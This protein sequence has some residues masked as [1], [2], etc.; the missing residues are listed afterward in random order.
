[1]IAPLD[2]RDLIIQAQEQTIRDLRQDVENQSALAK[3]RAE[4]IEGL[5]RTRDRLRKE[6]VA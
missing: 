3:S 2:E 1:M 6:A 4:E 5:R